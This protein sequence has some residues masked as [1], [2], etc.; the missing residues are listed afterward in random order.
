[1]F[2]FL[3]LGTVFCEKVLSVADLKINVIPVSICL[4]KVKNKNT[5]TRCELS[6]ELNKLQSCDNDASDVV[7]VLLLLTLNIIY[8]LFCLYC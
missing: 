6:I 1:M 4:L 5:K 7:L 8:N 3:N 2:I